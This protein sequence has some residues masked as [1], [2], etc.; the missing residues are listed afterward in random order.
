MNRVAVLRRG[1][2]L[3]GMTVGYNALEGVIAIATGLA[4]GSVALTGFGIDSVIEVTSGVLLWWRLRAELGSR[5]LGPAGRGAGG[6][7]GRRPAPRPRG[8]H[9]GRVGA[10]TAHRRSARRE[11]RGDRAHG[12]LI[13][14]DAPLGPSET[15][16]GGQSREPGTAGRR[17]RDDRV[18]VALR[19]DSARSGPERGARL[20]VGRSGSCSGDVAADRARADRGVEGGGWWVSVTIYVFTVAVTY[21][22]APLARLM[23]V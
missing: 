5:E 1:V 12:A 21:L 2:A 15:P 18:C 9:R 4:A 19:D 14:R 13:D 11:R 10:S 23:G 20:V 3:E 7:V 16:R 22:G 6:A 17:A 8:L